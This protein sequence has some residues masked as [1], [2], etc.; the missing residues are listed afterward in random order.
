MI[1]VEIEVYFKKS[2]AMRRG[3]LKLIRAA[4]RKKEAEREG[5][6]ELVMN[7]E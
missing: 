1:I 3:Q 6:K 4:N 5:M 7:G 2:N